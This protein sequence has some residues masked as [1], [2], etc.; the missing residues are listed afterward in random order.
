MKE[1]LKWYF[2]WDKPA[3]VCDLAG[4]ISGEKARRRILIRVSKWRS[5]PG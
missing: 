2:G 1:S 3:R 5:P 4:E